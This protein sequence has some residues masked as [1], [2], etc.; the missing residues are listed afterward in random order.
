M[1]MRTGALEPFPAFMRALITPQVAGGPVALMPVRHRLFL[2]RRCASAF[3]RRSKGIG[4]K[5]AFDRAH[6][7]PTQKTPFKV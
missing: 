4:I 1:L 2:R 7:R 3:T 5:E 6:R